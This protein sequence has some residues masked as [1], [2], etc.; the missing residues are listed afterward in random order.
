MKLFGTDGIRDAVGGEKMNPEIAAALGRA[1]VA[2]CRKRNLPKK[3]V[4]GRDT[5]ESGPMF[6]EAVASGIAAAGG[7]AAMAGVL[8]TPAVA[9][10][11]REQKAGA[12]IVISASHNPFQDNGFKPFK[13]DGTK[14]SEG[15]EK[16]I[17]EYILD[18]ISS[19]GNESVS[20]KRTIIADAKEKY[21]NFIL[22]NY[23]SLSQQNSN[24]NFF[25]KV[26]PFPPDRQAVGI[27]QGQ[28]L[29]NF[30]KS[31][32]EIVLDCANG[33]TCQVAPSIFEKVVKKSESIHASP[34]GKNINE[35]CGSQYPESLRKEVIAKKA[36][37]GLAF[38]GDGDR[39]IAV[40]EKGNVLTGDQTMYVIAKFLKEK[41]K[42][43][44]DLVVTTVMSNLGFVSALKK[45]G[46]GHAATAVGDRQVFF[47][48]Q[49][50]GA[51]L[52]G[53]ES[54][55]IIFS[56]FYPTGDGIT[57]G[58][59]LV[60]ALDHFKKPLSELAGEITLF[61]KLL[62]N[63]EVKSKPELDTIPEISNIIRETENKLGSEGRVLVR[64]SGTENLCRVMVEGK[65]A[66]EIAIFA[67]NIAETIK[68]HLS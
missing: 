49:K 40:D 56:D 16:E 37:L 14:L 28:T 55:H 26:R 23:Y 64:Y 27:P 33:A 5:R 22:E 65:D 15:E 58:L 2:F 19:N 25:S 41:G 13:N 7:E 30:P 12:G 10:L 17:E 9:W 39:V 34:D 32:F 67:N 61:P 31:N 68:K 57:G 42:L 18:K 66:E 62:A 50:K 44:N 47:E 8:P 46:I 35:N 3:I 45:L 24:Q 36:D 52:G 20:G 21:M 53:E 54:G 48:M 59:L 60:A 1:V 63:V 38:D 51:V 11:A 4:I 29:K 43:K 6:E